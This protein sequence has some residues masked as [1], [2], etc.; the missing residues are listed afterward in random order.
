MRICFFDPIEWDYTVE[1]PHQRALGGSQSALCYLAEALAKAGHGVALANKTRD[2][3]V[4][5]G[6]NCVGPDPGQTVDFL[7][8]FDAI[9]VLNA[10]LGANLR[11]VLGP[12]A[13]LVLWTQHAF[14]QKPMSYL[15]DEAERNAW[16]RFVLISDWQAKTYVETFG[17][18]EKKIV[19]RRNAVAPVFET[20]SPGKAWFQNKG[21]EPVLAYTSTPFR[22]LDVLLTAFPAI[23]AARPGARLR[24][25][26][27]MQVY[28][29]SEGPYPVLYELAKALPGVEYVGSRPQPE[30]AKAMAATGLLAYPNTFAET[31]CIAVM[32][33]MIAG[34][35]VITTD[36][37]ALPETTGGF[38][39]LIPPISDRVVHA[40]IFAQRCVQLIQQAEADPQ[41]FADHRARQ[42]AHARAN[43]VWSRRA[44]EWSETLT[45]LVAERS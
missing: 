8:G 39:F 40:A 23:R 11:R 22:G 1:T 6:V 14:D 25:Y 29:E 36:L 37:G 34:A 43:L 17:I 31:S 28:N 30:L 15:K 38:G 32:E 9:V 2:P 12:K 16:D 35:L 42:M 20:L 24:I 21:A 19:I 33:A 41:A 45:A 27:S 3:G 26:S 13:R 4:K 7:A 44:Q 5:R 10:A 18:P